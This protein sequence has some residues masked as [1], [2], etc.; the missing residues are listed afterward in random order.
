M[1]IH[2]SRGMVSKK[3]VINSANLNTKRIF[4]VFEIF[5][6]STKP[7]IIKQKCSELKTKS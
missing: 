5:F 4:Y 1:I 2:F 3:N 7:D 6:I